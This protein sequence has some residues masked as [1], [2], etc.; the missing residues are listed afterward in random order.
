MKRED[1]EKLG[2]LEKIIYDYLLKALYENDYTITL[3]EYRYKADGYIGATLTFG[4]YV[5][6]C[7][8]NHDRLGFICWHCSQTMEK[9]MR[10]LPHIERK[11]VA[12]A[13]RMVRENEAAYKKQRIIELEQELEQLKSA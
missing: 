11:L 2:T 6:R 4:G 9:L 8:I 10:E 1:Y 13:N 7:S 12:Q 5:V 3:D